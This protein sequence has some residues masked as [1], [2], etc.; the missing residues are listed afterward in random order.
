DIIGVFTV[1]GVDY[2]ALLDAEND[3]EYIFK[4]IENGE[5]FELDEVPEED[6]DEVSAEYDRLLESLDE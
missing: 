6:F 5:D 2:I 4:Y 1:K 3:Q